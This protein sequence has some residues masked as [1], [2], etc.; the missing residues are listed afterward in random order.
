MKT[1]K[2]NVYNGIIVAFIIL[3]SSSFFPVAQ[4][5]DIDRGF[6]KGPSYIPVVPMKKITFVNFDENSY[7]DDYA[8]LACIPTAVFRDNDKLF[9]NPLLFYQDYYPIKNDKERS[10]N[11][12]QGIDYFMDDWMTYCDGRLD[13]MT[14]VNVGEEDVIQWK[15]DEYVKIESDNPYEIAKEIALQDWSYSDDAVISMVE[16]TYKIPD[17]FTSSSIEETLTTGKKILTKTFYTQQLNKLQPRFH[18][19]EV[20]VGYK[21]L[22]SRTWWASFYIGKGDQFGLPLGINIT[23]PTADPDSQLYCK[24]DDEW[25][26]VA[27]TASWNIAGM[28]HEKAETYVYQNGLWRLGI[29]DVPTMSFIGRYG[30][31]VDIL[32]NL[33]GDVTYQT[34]ITIFPGVEL[35]IPVNP[36]F[37]CR[38]AKFKLTWDDQDVHLGFSLIGPSGEEVISASDE[39]DYQ[40]IYLDQLGECLPGESYSV[41]V[42]ALDDISKPVDFKVEF[43]WNQNFSKEKVDVFASAANGAVLASLLNAPLLYTA[44]SSLPGVTKDVLYKL[45]VK[46]VYLV[47][48]GG[49]LSLDVKKELKE[50]VGIKKCYIKSE[51]IYDE[52]MGLTGRN[53]VIFT[54]VDPWTQWLVT[55]MK[56]GNETVAGLFCGPAAYCAAHHGSPVLIVDFHPELSSAVV[57]HTEFW[58]RYSNG[59]G[60]PTV[61]PMYITGRRVYDFL[62]KYGFDGKG[63]ETMITVA[64]Q[65]EIGACW[66]RTFAGKAKPGRFFGSPV[67]TAYWISRSIFYPALIFNS[68]ALDPNGVKLINGSKS[69]RAE[70]LPW[71]NRGLKIVR[72][73][74]EEVFEYPTLQF[75]PCHYDHMNE[76]FST[77]FGFS[78]TCADGM[79]PGITETFNPIDDGASPGKEGSVWPDITPSEVVPF[80][81]EKG[82]LSSA[83]STNFSAVTEN[84]NRGVILWFTGTHG[85]S[86]NSGVL[87]SW[88]P[89]YSL[90]GEI[91]KRD[92]FRDR[93]GYMKE[94]NPWRGYEWYLGST[95]NPDT[96]TMEIHGFLPALLGDPFAKGLFP[97]GEDFW[98]SERPILHHIANLPI[99]R[100]F[101]PEWLK[102]SGYYKDGMVNAHSISNLGVSGSVFTGYNLDD[103]LKNVHSCGWIN[104]CCLTSYKYIHLTMV[105]HGSSFQVIDPWPTSWYCGVWMQSIPRDIVLGDTIGEAYLKGIKHVGILY[106]SDPPQ[107][108]WDD[109]ENVCFFGDPDLR[110]FIPDTKFSSNN[111]WTEEETAS[112]DYAEELSIG[113][114]M[115]F[116]ATGYPHEKIPESGGPYLILAGLIVL[117]L[118]LVI[119][120]I[121]LKRKKIK[122]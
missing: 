93:F 107:W 88:E 6:D 32:R 51:Q 99:L 28:D 5:L 67:D 54:T 27:V 45:G 8:Y 79:V 65:Y 71:G 62:E 57:W 64:D 12:R 115:P 4:A 58:K 114:H 1:G 10:L 42:F 69:V 80:Y 98:P 30:K 105:R 16:K 24:Y 59:F 116:G 29:T 120:V 60:K 46:N 63:E 83:F 38:N 111:Y 40:E 25:M 87:V 34:D 118:I 31:F 61:A 72:D 7:L 96:M 43:S 91:L 92:I 74:Q 11:A 73:S 35:D 23:I 84:L 21:Y 52:I 81:L 110:V 37:G 66:D 82:G 104:Y 39:G 47:D 90:I 48:L 97:T 33:L 109:G 18:E 100:W 56:P 50:V 113:G 94:S 103:T 17:N 2:L 102:D 41:S 36:C 9:S 101:L 20:P 76:R 119:L 68:P 106:V 44:S 77:Y 3:L 117:L 108:W 14:L 95:E 22:K 75:Y 78:Y 86:S 121:L 70:I 19:F 26:Q 13:Q 112:L 49:H 55:E 53:D 15:A 85:G 89:E 122:G